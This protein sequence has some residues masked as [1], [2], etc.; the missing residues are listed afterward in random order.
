MLET[1]SISESD[2]TDTNDV[3]K[4]V[5]S[6]IKGSA[7]AVCKR[8]D[9]LAYA[10]GNSAFKLDVSDS[11]SFIALPPS[12]DDYKTIPHNRRK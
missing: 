7:G 6:Y 2:I 3:A 9:R 10:F 4:I 12:I 8:N 1:R 5:D 11:T